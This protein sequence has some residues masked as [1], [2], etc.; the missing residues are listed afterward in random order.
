MN[1]V[2]MF[3]FMNKLCDDFKPVWTIFGYIIFAIKIV[4]PL[5][6]IVTGMIALAGAV[7]QQDEKEIKKYQG[8]LVQKLIAAA[9]VYLLI[10]ITGVI[11]SLVAADLDWK[12]CVDCT[13]SPFKEGNNCSITGGDNGDPSDYGDITK[14]SK[15]KDK[16]DDDNG[17][18]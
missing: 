8:V 16:D 10:T 14:P 17:S 2:D 9:V 3:S 7:M 4:V 12:T 5:L 18:R 13:F 15:D 6:L 1:L 11:V